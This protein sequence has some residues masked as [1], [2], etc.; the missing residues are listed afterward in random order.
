MVTSRLVIDLAAL[1]ANFRAFQKTAAQGSCAAVVKADAY[2][3]GVVPVAARLWR[4]GCREYFVATLAEGESLRAA[5]PQARIY[6]F[7]GAHA[8]NAKGLVEG[9]LIPVLNHPGQ[10]DCWRSHAPGRPAAVQ[11][12]TGMC[13]LGFEHE[14]PAELFDGVQVELLVTHFACADEPGHPLNQRQSERFQRLRARF[15]GVRVSLGNSAAMLTDPALVGDLGRPGIGLFGGNPFIG[16]AN[17]L[18]PVVSLQGRVLQVRD[19]QAG[20]QVGYGASYR[21]PRASSL[22]IVGVGYADGLPR[23]LSNR[24]AAW[25]AGERRPIVGRVSM[26]LTTI[27]VTGLSVRPGD[28]VE[29]FG[30]GIALDEVAAWA[31][32]IPYEVLTGLGSRPTRVYLG[33]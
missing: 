29:F 13:R 12:D 19:V 31:D 14:T 2:G 33:T 32:T 27:D 26:D 24:G 20:V 18:A 15:P 3:L 8:G 28:W 22:A 5:L 30:R 7:E 16:Q 1:A 6:V 11:F 9:E 23:S 4:E 21:A 10:L 25:V 17:P